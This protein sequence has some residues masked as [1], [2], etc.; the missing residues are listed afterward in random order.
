MVRNGPLLSLH[1]MRWNQR[2]L[3]AG[4]THALRATTTPRRQARLWFYEHIAYIYRINPGDSMSPKP[5]AVRP[6]PASRPA[7]NR[8]PDVSSS[9]SNPLIF[10]SHD[11]R[12]G[13]LAEAFS[14]LLSSVSAGMLKSFRSS[15]R[16]GTEGI[17][18]GV[19]WYPEVMAKLDLA[20]DVVCLLTPRSL[21]RP[22]LLYEAGVAKGKLNTPVHGVALGVSLSKAATGPFAQFQNSDDDESS[23]Q[24]L[25]LQLM[26][27][28]PGAEP[29]ADTVGMQV[30]AFKTRANGL[31]EELLKQSTAPEQ[32]G[33]NLQESSV[34]KL[35]EEV[36]VMFRDL[37]S[38]IDSKVA[39]TSMG[40]LRR[41][42]PEMLMDLR[43][44]GN[45]VD[46]GIELLILIS[47]VKDQAPWIYEVGLEAYS[48]LRAGNDDLTK[49]LLQRLLFVTE[50]TA[51]HP[52]FRESRMINDSM[53]ILIR[54]VERFTQNFVIQKS[55][56]EPPKK[57]SS[58]TP[59]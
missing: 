39:R 58:P 26:K 24:K 46:D 23:L 2:L 41:F 18:Y 34:A 21:E 6:K 51:H 53:F 48:A 52:M 19:D 54:E 5:V 43:H 44:F 32:S 40:R 55:T 42:R 12:D 47:M 50:L 25:V 17:E 1:G 11:S 14:K 8:Q 31:L 49:T 30:A 36:K 56:T 3:L 57:K 45:E 16:K 27:R 33:E 35:F 7:D 28:V 4:G 15:D 29:D 59:S 38:R 9:I 10:I 13:E 20:S 37:P 22:W